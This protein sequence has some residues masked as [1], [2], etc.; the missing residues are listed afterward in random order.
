MY[1]IGMSAES[2]QRQ[3]LLGNGSANMPVARQNL[4][5]RHVMAAP[6]K[7]ATIEELLEVFP[8]LSVPRLYK[9]DQL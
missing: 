1:C 6:Y 3:S 5:S 9:E 4:G 2:Q 7:Q 8:V